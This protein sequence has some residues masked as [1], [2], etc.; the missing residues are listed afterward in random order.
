MEPSRCLKSYRLE[1]SRATGALVLESTISRCLN[2]EF[3]FKG[4]LC[5]PNQIPIDKFRP[6]NLEQARQFIMFVAAADVTRLKFGDKKHLKGT[7]IFTPE[8]RVHGA[9]LL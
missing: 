1:L 8:V 2:K 9:R 5:R 3:H 4:K 7:E 6:E